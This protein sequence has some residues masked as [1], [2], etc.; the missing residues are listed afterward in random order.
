VFYLRTDL[1]EEALSDN[2]VINMLYVIENEE[3]PLSTFVLMF[4]P[5]TR[6]MAI[7]DIPGELGLLITGIKRVD[8][9]DSIY[10]PAKIS[11]Y[12]SEIQKLLGIDISFSIVITKDNMARL[13][14]L[15]NGVEVFIPAQIEMDGYILFPSGMTVLDGD[16]ASIYATY[17]IPEEE[18]EMAVFRRQRFFLGFLKKQAEMNA[19][20]K[21][22]DIAG[23]YHSFLRTNL[24]PQTTTRLFDELANIDAERTNIQSVGGSLREV[25][26]QML[27]IPHWDGNLIK[28]IVRQTSGTLTRQIGGFETDR[29][30]TVE[31]LNGTA[32]NGLAGRTAELLR[33]FGFDVIAIRNADRN[34]Y[35]KTKIIDRS[36]NDSIARNFAE[37]IRCENMAS[38]DPFGENFESGD[39][40][41]YQPDFTLVI[42]RDFNGRYVAGN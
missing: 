40:F 36:G 12:I 23:M 3:K 20:I 24:N 18:Q 33:S 8:R 14:D 35:E 7:I 38:E 19:V 9:I 32:V 22:P 29:A 37:V 2:R 17:L 41:E 27:L 39:N 31:V 34:D 25:S 42:G 21:N 5:A 6:R 11:G 4:Y 16:K 28:E 26:G 15:L 1:V 30:F 13:V 10:D